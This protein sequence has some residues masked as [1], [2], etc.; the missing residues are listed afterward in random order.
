MIS[1][2][3]R[4]HGHV[5]G[6]FGRVHYHSSSV[7]VGGI[8]GLNGTRMIGSSDEHHCHCPFFFCFPEASL[9]CFLE[10]DRRINAMLRRLWFWFDWYRVFGAC[11]MQLMLLLSGRGTS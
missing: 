10:G 8:I 5:V 1:G 11:F 9:A 6:R 4:C 2:D 3:G 7:V